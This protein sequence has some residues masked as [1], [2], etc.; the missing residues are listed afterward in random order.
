MLLWLRPTDMIHTSFFK[1][2]PS[3]RG[4]CIYC[5]TKAVFGFF[6]FGS[7]FAFSVK[8][9]R[10]WCILKPS[11]S[12]FFFIFPTPREHNFLSPEFR[13]PLPCAPSYTGAQSESIDVLIN[14]APIFHLGC[15][16]KLSFS[17]SCTYTHASC[18]SLGPWNSFNQ[19]FLFTNTWNTFKL[20]QFWVGIETVIT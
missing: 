3:V 17:H 14:M 6:F 13:S 15:L 10:R 19:I 7:F 4:V 1:K 20:F 8:S 18:P 5:S 11:F 16:Y 12:R 9:A 2:F